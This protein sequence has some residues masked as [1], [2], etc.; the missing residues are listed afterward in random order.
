M[1][2]GQYH[3]VSM[4]SGVSRSKADATSPSSMAP[5]AETSSESAEASPIQSVPKQGGLSVRRSGGSGI[6]CG[7]TRHVKVEGS[8]HRSAKPRA[9][10][11]IAAAGDPL[12]PLSRRSS[13]GSS[14]TFA[15]DDSTPCLAASTTSR[16]SSPSADTCRCK[17]GPSG[18]KG[19]QL[20]AGTSQVCS[21]ERTSLPVAAGKSI[22]STATTSLRVSYRNWQNNCMLLYKHIMS[23]ILE[24]P[25]LSV[26]WLHSCNP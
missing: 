6:G 14:V 17:R 1:T 10:S 22:S 25:T 15:T 24:W 4:A 20:S 11:A 7:A 2:D 23:H 13:R 16:V 18:P 26:Q 3:R 19:P 21:D 12:Q 5:D 9:G 8:R